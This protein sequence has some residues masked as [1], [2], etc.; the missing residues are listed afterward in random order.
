MSRTRGDYALLW[1]NGMTF[2]QVYDL[3]KADIETEV[4]HDV[5]PAEFTG[6]DDFMPGDA[7]Y[8]DENLVTVVERM[9]STRAGSDDYRVRSDNGST[10]TVWGSDLV[11]VKTEGSFAVVNEDYR[12]AGED[13]AEPVNAG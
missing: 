5:H 13:G 12:W 10:Y 6:P 9:S 1:A 8:Y 3:M 2:G 7:A 4:H 11:R